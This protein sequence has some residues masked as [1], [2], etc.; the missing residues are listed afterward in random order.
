MDYS[1][2]HVDKALK[3]LFMGT[4]EFSVP[5]LEGLI[6]H[7]KIRAIV[8]QPDRLK[9]NGT[10]IPTPIKKVGMNNTILVIQPEKISESISE[11][12]SLEPDLI[13]T[14]AYGQILPKE[15]IEYPR[16]G[17]INVHASLLPKLRGGAPIHRSI[18]NGHSKTGITIMHMDVGMDTGDI[19]SQEEIEIDNEDTAS[20]LHDKLS[21]L[22]RDLLLKT[23][24]S[25]IDGTAGRTKQD[26]SKATYGFVIKRKDER[27][28][29]S[30]TKRQVYN[31][32][33]GLN[34]WPGAYCYFNGKILKVWE[35]YPTDNYYSSVFDGEI[36]KI[37]EDGF[38]VKVSNGEIV[39][40]TVQPEGKRKMGA[41]DFING[42]SNKGS[43]I[44][45]IL[46]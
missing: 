21:I 19:I 30:K 40:K 32:I 10:N 41:I 46:D 17:C 33:R 45:K 34:S 31:Q 14:A 6:E 1:N 26:E 3:I 36:T 5:I 37:Y 15:I 22:G 24:P 9:K 39:L 12:L 28:N 18:I 25:I 20:T 38:G 2:I 13:I 44:G 11:V 35:S 27:I 8:T 16:L 4:P 7:Y 29:F 43:I 23:L 42:L